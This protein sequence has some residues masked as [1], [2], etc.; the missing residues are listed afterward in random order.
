MTITATSTLVDL[1]VPAGTVVDHYNIVLSD[2]QTKSIPASPVPD[3][4]STTF[5]VGPGTYTAVAS[6]IAADGSVIG[7]PVTSNTLVVP[8]PTT[9]TVK[10]P[11]ALVLSQ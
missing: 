6:A 4:L 8:V 11:A 9:I 7:T 2:G 3:H 5:E 1:T 10:I